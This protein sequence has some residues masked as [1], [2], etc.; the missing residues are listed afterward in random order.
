MCVDFTVLLASL[1]FLQTRFFSCTHLRRDC[2][3]K[4]A[5]Q[6]PPTS[7]ALQA[8]RARMT[9]MRPDGA[10]ARRQLCRHQPQGAAQTT[11]LDR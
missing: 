5:F 2:F 8:R 10:G 4:T 1:C 11:G 3:L 7:T 9:V 6:Y